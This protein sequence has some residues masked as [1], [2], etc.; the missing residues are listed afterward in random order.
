[1]LLLDLLVNGVALEVR[2]VL[3]E[4]HALARVLLVLG[5]D[6]PG[7]AGNTA[8]SLFGAFEDDLNPV[9]FLC[10]ISKKLNDVD[11]TFFTGGFDGLGQTVL[12]D[13]LHTLAGDLQG[14]ET[15]FLFQPETLGLEVRGEF[16]FSTSLG[17]GNIVSNH[18]LLTCNL[19]NSCNLCI[20]LYYFPK[21]LQIS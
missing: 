17:V 9:A 12:V 6:I 15:L 1:M 20:F 4:F 10:H 16:A 18:P 21:G 11:Q 3:L 5:R 19:T 7:N 8:F 14:H 2:V 13:G